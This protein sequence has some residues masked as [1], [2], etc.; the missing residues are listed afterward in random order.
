[1]C[2]LGFAAAGVLGV[3]TTLDWFEIQ[4]DN[5]LNVVLNLV[6]V[7]FV[8]VEEIRI[9]IAATTVSACN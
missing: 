6:G 7:D 1:M 2:F 8:V 9:A 3:F 5:A 4:L